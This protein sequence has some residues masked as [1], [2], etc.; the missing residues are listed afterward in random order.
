M[1]A[2]PAVTAMAVALCTAT[3]ASADEVLATRI[4]ASRAAIKSFAGALQ[5]QLMSAMAASGPTA[6]IEVCKIAAPEIAAE[7]SD[8][9]SWRIGRTSLKLR[10]PANAPDA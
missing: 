10:N 3:A 8:A 2:F 7:A 5:E 6:A 1:R 9:Q 4:G